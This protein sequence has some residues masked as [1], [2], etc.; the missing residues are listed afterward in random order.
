MARLSCGVQCTRTLLVVLNII[1]LISGFAILGLGIYI[2]VDGNFN[3]IVAAHNITQALGSAAMHWIGTI[4]ITVGSFTVCLATFGCLGAACQ[5]RGFLYVYAVILSLV[6]LVE[7]AAVIVTLQYRNDVWSSYD[8][9]FE[10]IFQ[11]AYR[12]NQTETI[13]I[14]EELERKFQCC[15]VNSYA[16]YTQHLYPIPLSCRQYQVPSGALFS[17]GCAQ[18]VGLWIWNQLPIIAGVLGAILFIEIFGV[19]ASVAL[20]VAI[21][22]SSTVYTYDKF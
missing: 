7:S 1:F 2:K 16:D 10:E 8:S 19:V 15:G 9:G 22:H 6:I 4:M 12:Y 18:A 14:I 20:G 11:H 21:S 13:E 5:N 17:R 3:A